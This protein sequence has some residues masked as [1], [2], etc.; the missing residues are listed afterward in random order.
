MRRGCF[1][2]CGGE[3]VGVAVR[4]GERGGGVLGGEIAGA[5]IAVM[6]VVEIMGA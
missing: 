5:V 6:A 2:G 4:D 3:E 1:I